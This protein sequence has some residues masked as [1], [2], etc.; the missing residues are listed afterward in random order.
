[1]TDLVGKRAKELP[2]S[3][4]RE[5]FDLAGKLENVIH[6]E[7]GE[8]DFDTP[9][10]IIQGAFRAAMDGM[11]HYTG[12]AGLLKLRARIAE[13]LTEQL[14]VSYGPDNIVVTA[15]GMEALLLTMFVALN[16]EDEVVFPSPHWPNYP[17]HVLLAGGRY[18]KLSLSAD[19]GFRPSLQALERTVTNDTKMLLL[20]YPHNPTGAVMEADDLQSIAR[21]A[22]QRDVIVC[23]DEAYETL[24]YDGRK[25]L[26]I[27]SLDG[28][29]D[30]TVIIRT[31]SKTYAMTGWRI[32][33]LAAPAKFAKRAGKLHE[34]TSAC[35]SS[36]SQMA[37][38]TALD[39]S[40]DVSQSM[41]EEY[42][43]RR[44]IVMQYL[45]GVPEIR[46]LKP[47]GTFYAFVDISSFGLSSF[48]FSRRLLEKARVAVAPGSAFGEEGEGYI[49]IC[50]ANS[51]DNIKR[52][53]ERMEKMIK[54]L[55]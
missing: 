49:R 53:L 50:F 52:G 41:V 32:G 13:R 11:T 27:A 39:T 22:R 45:Q 42:E 8:P 12:S 3:G 20:N 6:F 51:V 54:K 48:D 55:S 29:Q 21:F 28:M 26:S 10:P 47:Q 36:V 34:H 35:T 30:R 38:L 7:I 14:N 16:R 18:A 23:S 31:F 4:I 40:D 1:M 33:Y 44:D 43:S 24:V 19:D 25:F 46:I 17:A 15:G 37:A 9:K 5:I 2:Y